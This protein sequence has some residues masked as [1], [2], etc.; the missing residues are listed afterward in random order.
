MKKPEQQYELTKSNP[1]TANE[2]DIKTPI[3]PKLDIKKYQPHIE[4][5]DLTDEEQRNL[6]ETLWSI[7]TS[8]VDIGFGVDVVQLLFKRAASDSFNSEPDALEIKDQLNNFNHISCKN[9]KKGG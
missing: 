7:M 1:L 2:L 6:L 4:E 3:V 8:F 5:F 9:F